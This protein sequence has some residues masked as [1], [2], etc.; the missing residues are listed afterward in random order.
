MKHMQHPESCNIRLKKQMKHWKQTF[1]TYVY[2]HCNIPIYFRNI[3]I[4]HWQHTSETSATLET[5]ACNMCFRA[6]H[7]LV[8]Y[9]IE[10]RRRVEFTEGSRAIATVDQTDSAYHDAGGDPFVVVGIL[11]STHDM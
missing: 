10:A 3:H 2:N 1:A 11:G 8:A 4:K 6:R 5:D 7:L 9:K